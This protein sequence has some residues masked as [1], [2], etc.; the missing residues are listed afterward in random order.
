MNE[1]TVIKNEQGQLLVDSREVALMVE[2]TH[3]KLLRDIRGYITVIEDSPKLE[4]QDFFV[5][6]TYICFGRD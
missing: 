1:L 2:K 5:E 4:S 6:S 3:D